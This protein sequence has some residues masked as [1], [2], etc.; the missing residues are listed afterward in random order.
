MHSRYHG[1]RAMKAFSWR[2]SLL[3]LCCCCVLFWL[4]GLLAACAPST[5]PA[6]ATSVSVTPTATPTGLLL[7]YHGHTLSVQGVAWSPDGKSIASAS[8]D[9]TV[10]V[11][12]AATG[13]LLYTHSSPSQFGFNAVA[14]SPDGTRL[15]AACADNTVQV[16]DAFTGA[17]PL[18]YRGHN[19]PVLSVA[20][21][22]D[23]R[24]IASAGSTLLTYS[25]HSA[26]V[27]AVA[28]SPDGKEIASGSSD[29]TVQVWDAASGKTLL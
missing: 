20:W 1:G 3:I 4:P 27:N 15:A 5:L 10:Q 6:A 29:S 23:G 24:Q 14:W 16:W 9:G 8:G 19:A 22:P 12:D 18:T 13:K 17:H 21:S 28:W 2:R 11:W 26:A 7:A 25:G